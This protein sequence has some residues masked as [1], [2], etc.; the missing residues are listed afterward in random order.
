ME[1]A[2][3]VNVCLHVLWVP[4]WPALS[5]EIGSLAVALCQSVLG[6][7]DRFAASLDG[8]GGLLHGTATFGDE[9]R[10]AVGT[11]VP[12]P[13]AEADRLHN[14]FVDRFLVE[15]QLFFVR[16]D[17]LLK[18]LELLG[19]SYESL[20]D[21]GVGKGHQKLVFRVAGPDFESDLEAE[22][23]AVHRIEA[24]PVQTLLLHLFDNWLEK[25]E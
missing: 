18:V 3:K 8:A 9:V 23:H 5:G 4:S 6:A 7:S 16:F 14:H 1:T 22:Y 17:L 20:L 21:D 24:I 2:S 11:L 19:V 15:V 25:R 13:S 12:M 10:M